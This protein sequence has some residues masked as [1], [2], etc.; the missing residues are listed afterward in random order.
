MVKRNCR[1][2]RSGSG[3]SPRRRPTPPSPAAPD[4]PVGRHPN[5]RMIRCVV[6][7]AGVVGASVAHRLAASGVAVTVLE[8]GRVGGGTSGVSFAWTNANNKPPRAYHDL[9]V[10]GMR[11]HAALGEEFGG[12]P[13]W[14]GGGSVE[15]AHTDAGQ[16]GLRE[17][18]ERLRSWGYAAEWVTHEQ[19]RELEPDIDLEAVGDGPI[20]YFPEE[21]WLDP[22]LYAH[23]M[24][25][26]APGRGASRGC[27]AR[28]AEVL[29][30]G[31]GLEAVRVG[32]R[33]SPADGFSAAGPTPGVSG[34][35]LAVTPS[36]VTLPP[37][38]GLA[39]AQEIAGGRAVPALTPFRPGR[40]AAAGG[41]E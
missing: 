31:A 35:S 6:I 9:N 4:R 12:T 8:A 38:L 32:V 5:A 7:G 10:A 37:F 36:G 30:E 24:L 25:E 40:F 21:G 2:P 14:H 20:A 39:A 15:W 1:S 33:P 3:G 29:V 13:W 41:R 22:V 23:A 16:A 26:A 11:A 18:V 19:L 27:G 34:F 17:R 28:V